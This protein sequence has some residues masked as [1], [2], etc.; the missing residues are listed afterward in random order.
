MNEPLLK[1]W[2][3]V[4]GRVPDSRLIILSHAGSH[5]RRTVEIFEGEEIDSRRIGFVEPCARRDYLD[6]YH[7]LDIVLDP[8]PYHGHT[9]SLD[10]LWMGVP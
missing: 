1:L 10:A 7:R 3:K 4:L 5:R 2:A 6:F 9:T 8:F